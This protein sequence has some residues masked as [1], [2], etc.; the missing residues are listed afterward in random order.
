MAEG[1]LEELDEDL[2]QLDGGD[3]PLAD[4]GEDNT[5]EDN[6]IKDL[7]IITDTFYRK[8]QVEEMS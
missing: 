2:A 5:M 6:V 1:E 4:Q 3:M 8:G 7:V